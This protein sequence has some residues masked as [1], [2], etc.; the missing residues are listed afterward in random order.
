MNITPKAALR[1]SVPVH[2]EGGFST[3]AT[4]A[5]TVPSDTIFVSTSLMVTNETADPIGIFVSVAGTTIL[6]WIPVPAHGICLLDSRIV[7]YEGDTIEAEATATGLDL[8]LDGLELP[9]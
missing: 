3:M 4:V 6:S 2:S 1:C 7:A 5:Y 8:F 9:Q